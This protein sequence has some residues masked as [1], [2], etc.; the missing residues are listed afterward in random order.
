[1][2]KSGIAESRHRETNEVLC[3]GDSHLPLF[4][5]GEDLLG[6]RDIHELD[7]G[8]L[9]LLL[10]GELVWVMDHCK[11]AVGLQGGCRGV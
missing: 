10:A 11:V 8:S 9:L 6:G 3:M 5:V 4:R 2:G 7:L 1:M